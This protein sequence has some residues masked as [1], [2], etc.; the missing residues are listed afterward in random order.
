MSTYADAVVRD[1]NCGRKSLGGD[2]EAALHTSSAILGHDDTK[3]GLY[4]DKH[5]ELNIGEEQRR[6]WM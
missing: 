6:Q 2:V 4:N 5:Q 1:V 3:H